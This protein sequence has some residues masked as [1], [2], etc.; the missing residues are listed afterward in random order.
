MKV[1]KL[2]FYL[3]MIENNRDNLNELELNSIEVELFNEITSSKIKGQQIADVIER[4]KNLLSKKYNSF[5]EFPLVFH[6]NLDTSIQS[7]LISR[8]QGKQIT[9]ELEDKIST[10]LYKR[11][12]IDRKEQHLNRTINFEKR[13]G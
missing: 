10:M 4:V 8:N 2:L 12:L 5:Q 9:I 3:Y 11:V 13:I 1:E 6:F 7:N